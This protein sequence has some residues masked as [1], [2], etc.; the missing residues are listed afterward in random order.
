MQLTAKVKLQVTPEQ[1]D[2]LKRTIQRANKCC[3]WLSER[4]WVKKT[5]SQ[6]NLHKL[7]YYNARTEFPDLGSCV[8]IR[9]L[10]KVAQSYKLNKRTKRKFKTLGA[11]EYDKN[12]L[13]WH[14]NKRTVSIW[15]LDGRMKLPFIAGEHQLGLLQGKIGQADL[16]FINGEFYLSTPCFVE[17]PTPQDVHDVL[18]CDLGIVNILT[19]SDG[20]THSGEKIETNRRK[21]THRRRNLQHKGTRSAKRKLK[22][23]SGKQSHFQRDVNHRISKHVVQ[24]AHDTQRAIAL[25]D[26]S[27]IREAKVRRKQRAKHA[28]WSF[29]QLRNFIQYKAQRAGIPVFLV[30]PRNTSRT[31]HA[32]GCIDKANR[33]SQDK[34][35]CI[36][37]GFAAPADYNASLIIR[38]RAAVNQPM[39]TNHLI[40]SQA[41]CL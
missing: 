12:L 27:G 23:L 6:F 17:E 39:V 31:C 30:D 7:V 24:K 29:F 5:F 1:A 26:L 3:D 38:D 25:E 4:A 34:F 16:S 19:D 32:C 11:I 21:Y 10:S 20:E 37:C 36:S 8:V 14:V 22:K 18:G 15:T 40:Q 28:N 35:L 33:P 2:A 41:V 13:S 9:C